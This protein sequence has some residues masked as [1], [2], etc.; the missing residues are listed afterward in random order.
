M[1]KILLV[2]LVLFSIFS[3]PA[4]LL[5][6]NFEAISLDW[7]NVSC[8]SDIR[9]NDQ[10][11]ETNMSD[12]VLYVK[13]DAACDNWSGA[14]Y[15]P[16]TPIAGYNYLHVMMY[17]NNANQPNLKISDSHPTGGAVDLL[18][19]N[20]IASYTWQDVVFDISGFGAVDFIMFM[21]DRTEL[22]ETA[23][24]LCDEVLLS[25]DPTPRV[26]VEVEG[27]EDNEENEDNSSLDEVGTGETDG[28]H[29]VWADYFNDGTLNMDNWS[30]EVNGDGGGNNELQYYRAEN[31]SVGDEPNTGKGCLI[32][33]AKKENYLGKTA[34]S[35]RL[36]TKDK[37]YF[38]HGKVEASI[39][40]PHTA[41][42]LWPAFW[43]MGNDLGE[44]G[45]PRCGEIDIVEMGHKDGITA[46]AQ[47]RY[48]NGACH[49][50]F[51]NEQGQYPNYAKASTNSYGMQDDFHLFTL[52]WDQNELRMYLDQDK[53]PD[54]DPYFSMGISDMNGDWAVGNYFHKPCFVLLNLAVGGNFPQ[55]WDINEVTA[56]ANGPA[57]MY[58]DYVKVY[59]KGM[60]DETFTHVN[61][62]VDEVNE[63]TF[64]CYPNPTCD[65][66]RF[67]RPAQSIEV[68]NMMGQVILSCQNVD[69]IDATE[70]PV[71]LYVAK[72]IVDGNIYS[73]QIVKK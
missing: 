2:G 48:F 13:R 42:G 9:A 44:V 20:E 72:I 15:T 46:N 73:K 64:R 22:A 17:R 6:D 23:W 7:E 50:G 8:Y 45:W 58:V 37:M 40:F 65:V 52:Y 63:D 47:D 39:K 41:N 4:Q 54:V 49:W 18:P 55:I 66:F 28:Y 36:I 57:Y 11:T 29:L 5:V 27:G 1:K 25:N 33:T 35:G 67:N 24:M 30:I 61:T 19:M 21:V 16:E 59:Q 51:Y 60:A 14:I 53:Y 31:V 3:S 56:L 26:A 32:I 10:K 71:G 43:M 12:K 68:V 34:T 62:S 38:T 69:Q 70:W